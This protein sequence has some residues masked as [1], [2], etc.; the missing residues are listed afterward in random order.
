MRVLSLYVISVTEFYVTCNFRAVK[1]AKIV[2]VYNNVYHWLLI[3]YPHLK[4]RWLD[5]YYTMQG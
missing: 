2:K 4:D 5:L 3:L 1:L